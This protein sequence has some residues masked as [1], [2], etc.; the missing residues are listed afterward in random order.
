M[1]TER[2]PLARS[3]TDLIRARLDRVEH[4]DRAVLEALAVVNAPT[5][6]SIV[7]ALLGIDADDVERSLERLRGHRLAIETERIPRA[8]LPPSGRSNIRWSPRW[9][10]RR[11]STPPAGGCTDDCSRS[12]PTLRSAGA[13]AT[14]SSPANRPIGSPRS[15]CSPTP[16][17]RH[18]HGPHLRRPSIRCEG[19]LTLLEPGDDALR[20][21]IERDLGIAYLRQLEVDPP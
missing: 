21:R 16:G 4:H 7:A 14:R 8:A 2:T 17:P 12:I 18:W 10:R 20:H 11:W 6:P 9:S 19:A 1:D 5:D 13:P 15:R 3:A